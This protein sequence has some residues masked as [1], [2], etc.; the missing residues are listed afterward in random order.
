MSLESPPPTGSNDGTQ[1]PVTLEN[2]GERF[3]PSGEQV[4]MH[5]EHATR[6]RYAARWSAGKRVLDYACGV[7]FGTRILAATD[8]GTRAVGI[9]LCAAAVH[10]AE[11]HQGGANIAY[12]AGDGLRLPFGDATFDLVVAFEFIEHVARQVESLAE[13]Q[14]VL[15]PEGRLIVST[16]NRMQTVGR[17]PFHIHE[18]S[19]A[20]FHAMLGERFKYVEFVYQSNMLASFITPPLSLPGAHDIENGFASVIGNPFHPKEA[21]F[22]V[23][24]CSNSP[25]AAHELLFDGGVYVTRNDEY[26]EIRGQLEQRGRLIGAQTQELLRAGPLISQLEQLFQEKRQ[27]ADALSALLA[28][29]R[30]RG[31]QLDALILK[32]SEALA[33]RDDDMTRLSAEVT[34]ASHA[35]Q[36]RADELVTT[37]RIAAETV[38]RAGQL[39][40]E[41]KVRRIADALKSIP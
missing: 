38:S 3:M 1:R 6:Y 17:N 30:D 35:L 37:A 27:A 36:H 19:E 29:L 12:V 28:A 21:L 9:D 40:V 7:G 16:P 39:R 23:A 8:P 10:Y 25:L 31:D 18:L 14:R 32:L 20:E 4:M 13:M 41:A 15:T 24:V 2:T 26:H 33:R 11:V 5:A 22:I 34:A